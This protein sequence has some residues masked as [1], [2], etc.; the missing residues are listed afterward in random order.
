MTEEQNIKK[1]QEKLRAYEKLLNELKNECGF[2]NHNTPT[3]EYAE[4][5]CKAVLKL[6]EADNNQEGYDLID[7]NNNKTYQIKGR[8]FYGK[9][10]VQFDYFHIDEKGKLN[11]DYLIGVIFGEQFAVEQV[12]Q[13]SSDM[14]L[15]KGLLR[16]TKKGY[17][18]KFDDVKKNA[19][20]ITKVFIN[21]LG[22]I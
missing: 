6:K 19:E 12:Y 16:E 3:G 7:T 15:D 22:K 20:D 5:L 10:S 11:F 21:Y 13:I 1:I 4:K 2:K 9:G 18:V 17:I 14:L 8:R